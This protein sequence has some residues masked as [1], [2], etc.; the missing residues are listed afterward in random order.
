MTVNFPPN[1][2]ILCMGNTR[3]YGWDKWMDYHWM[4][5]TAFKATDGKWY[6]VNDR[7]R[8]MTRRQ[9]CA[10]HKANGSW[11]GSCLAGAYRDGQDG[12]LAGVFGSCRAGSGYFGQGGELL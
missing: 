8:R 11:Y 9:R 12:V 2:A 1:P 3:Y 4:A 6:R 10:Y 7:T 5:N